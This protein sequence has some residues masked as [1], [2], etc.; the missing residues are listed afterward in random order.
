MHLRE[1]NY[2]QW[3]DAPKSQVEAYKATAIT[4]PYPEGESYQDTSHRMKIFLQRLLKDYGGKT[5]LIIGHRAT[6]YGLEE[7][8]NHIPLQDAVLAPWKWQPGW[9]YQLTSVK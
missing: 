3:N 8:I 4:T 5:V 7:W 2:G 1:C 6:Q 9:T